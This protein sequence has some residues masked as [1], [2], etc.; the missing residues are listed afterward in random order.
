[1]T[2]PSPSAPTV[3]VSSRSI[4][5]D[6]EDRCFSLSPAFDAIGQASS[7]DSRWCDGYM[8][9]PIQLNGLDCVGSSGGMFESTL[10]PCVAQSASHQFWLGG[11]WIGTASL[12]LPLTLLRR[13]FSDCSSRNLARST[14]GSLIS[15]RG[16]PKYDGTDH[17]R[18]GRTFAAP[19]DVAGIYVS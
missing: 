4:G 1:M 3:R 5:Y 14:S 10:L 7:V 12:A 15:R 19:P 18:P 9:G 8:V 2:D 11:G 6:S 13:A 17:W 16:A